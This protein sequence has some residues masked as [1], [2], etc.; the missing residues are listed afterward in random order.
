MLAPRAIL[1]AAALGLAACAT[2]T[3]NTAARDAMARTSGCP[4][5]RVA[6]EELGDSR[7]RATGCQRSETYVCKVAG[8]AVVSCVPEAS[9]PPLGDQ[10][11]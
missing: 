5:D 7:Y 2:A 3:M 11:K 10:G 8:H 6:V 4:A 9:V 1:A